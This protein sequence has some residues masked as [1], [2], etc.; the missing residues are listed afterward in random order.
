MKN[1]TNNFAPYTMSTAAGFAVCFAITVVT[2]AKEAWDN[3]A[4]FSIGIP[5][6]CLLIFGISYK[7]PLNPWRWAVAQA[8]GQSIA[9]SMAGNSFNLW[10][11]SIIGMSIL[12]APQLGAA[13]LAAKLAQKKRMA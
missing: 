8:V 7:F 3:S 6:M 4:Y 13:F 9:I 12:S 11:L 1:E 10:P 5:T 2:G